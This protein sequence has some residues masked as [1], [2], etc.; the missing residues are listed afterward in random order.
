MSYL[1]VLGDLLEGEEDCL[2]FPLLEHVHQ[3]LDLLVPPV[4]LFKSKQTADNF[5]KVNKDTCPV[6]PCGS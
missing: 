1:E 5:V 4:E 2:I 6:P 3:I